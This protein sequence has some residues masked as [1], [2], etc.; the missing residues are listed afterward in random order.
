MRPVKRSLL[1]FSICCLAVSLSAQK[2]FPD[3]PAANFDSLAGTKN[4]KRY[5]RIT[6]NFQKEESKGE[7]SVSY[8]RFDRHGRLLEDSVYNSRKLYKYDKEGRLTDCKVYSLFYGEVHLDEE[9]SYKM[10]YNK[11]GRLLRQVFY[12]GKTIEYSYN[13]KGRVIREAFYQAEHCDS[14]RKLEEYTIFY[15]HRKKLLKKRM[16]YGGDSSLLGYTILNYNPDGKVRE[17]ID[18]TPDGEM[19]GQKY[20]SYDE[21]G[22]LVKLSRL[23]SDTVIYFIKYDFLNRIIETKTTDILRRWI[24]TQSYSYDNFGNMVRWTKVNQSGGNVSYTQTTE[25]FYS[26]GLLTGYTSKD[27]HNNSSEV[28]FNFTMFPT[29]SGRKKGS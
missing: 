16:N 9:D 21:K 6:R 1:L 2:L 27:S 26:N 7:T 4:V 13:K 19:G 3:W 8:Y 23:G 18:I 15:Y 24:T 25:F 5:E 20:Y 29:S 17:E 14:T 10:F 28:K 22:N 12:C 11:K